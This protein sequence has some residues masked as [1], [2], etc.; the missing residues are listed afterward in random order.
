M[1]SLK[2]VQPLYDSNC[3]EVINSR[4]S[5]AEKI[6]TVWSPLSPEQASIDVSD[7]RKQGWPAG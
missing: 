3:N 2:E 7:P 1:L 5:Q 4:I 6:Q